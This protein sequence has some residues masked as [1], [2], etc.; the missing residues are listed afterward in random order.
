MADGLATLESARSR[1]TPKPAGTSRRNNTISATLY[2]ELRAEIVSMVRCPGEVIAEKDIARKYGVSR[3][4]VREALLRL[5]DE[6]LVDIFPQFGTFVSRIALAALPEAFVIRRVLEEAAVRYA[7]T[8]ATPGQMLRLEDNLAEQRAACGIGNVDAFHQSDECFHALIADCAGYPRFWT[9][10]QQVKVQMDRCRRL[11]LPVAG[12]IEAVIAEHQ[13]IVDAIV[14]HDPDR[15]ARSM[16][17]H[18]EGLGSGIADIRRTNPR[19][20][21]DAAG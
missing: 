16:A 2:R 9:I 13:E 15:A 7:A 12:R 1:R 18:L 21:V 10:I 6:G 19:Y 11:T 4:P 5:A 8:G 3:T 14:A 20:F 17:V